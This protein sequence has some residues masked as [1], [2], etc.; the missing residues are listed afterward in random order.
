MAVA[1]QKVQGGGAGCAGS[2]GAARRSGPRVPVFGSD[3]PQ[4][5]SRQIISITA[6]EKSGGS[7]LRSG[8]FVIRLLL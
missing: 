5:N 3:G 7:L 8:V 4:G 1:G 2:K 6:I